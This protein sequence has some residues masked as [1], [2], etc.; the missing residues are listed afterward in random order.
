MMLDI[1]F[2]FLAIRSDTPD[3][4][5]LTTKF[6]I[7]FICSSSLA[8]IS[9]RTARKL[10]YNLHLLLIQKNKI[11]MYRQPSGKINV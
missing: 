1:A 10:V 4:E 9:C 8:G 7:P 3:H 6:Q 5:K 2:R 11:K